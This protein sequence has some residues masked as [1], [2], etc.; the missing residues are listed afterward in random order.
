[1]ALAVEGGRPKRHPKCRFLL[2]TQAAR[3]FSRRFDQVLNRLE[4]RPDLLTLLVLP[5]FELFQ[6]PC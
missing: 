2:R 1:M 4:H 6:S 5:P 3:L